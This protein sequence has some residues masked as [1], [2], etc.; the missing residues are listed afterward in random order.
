MAANQLELNLSIPRENIDKE[1][2]VFSRMLEVLHELETVLL[3]KW[4][5]TQQKMQF[6]QSDHEDSGLH[7]TI[8][9][10]FSGVL[11]DGS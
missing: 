10:E 2:C 7:E 5:F 6:T 11:I 3:P 9:I 8:T 1:M 4:G